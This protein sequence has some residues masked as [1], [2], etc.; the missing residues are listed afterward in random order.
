MEVCADD[1]VSNWTQQDPEIKPLVPRE[2]QYAARLP[3]PYLQTIDMAQLPSTVNARHSMINKSQIAG[4]DKSVAMSGML[5]KKH[6]KINTMNQY[7]LVPEVIY[8]SMEIQ[9]R[10]LVNTLISPTNYRQVDLAKQHQEMFLKSHQ[11][12]LRIRECQLGIK[13]QLN[14]KAEFEAVNNR[15]EGIVSG[16]VFFI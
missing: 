11:L 9:L 1:L 10:E 7:D 12:D 4:M 3:L 14:M 13:K 15:M 16:S 6:Q 2:E 5:V 8:N